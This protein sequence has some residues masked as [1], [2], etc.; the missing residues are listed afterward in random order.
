MGLFPEVSPFLF[1][2]LN[3]PNLYEIVIIIDVSDD[4]SLEKNALSNIMSS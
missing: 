1:E 3:N 4:Y 2:V